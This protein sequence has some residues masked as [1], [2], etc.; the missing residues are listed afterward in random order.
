MTIFDTPAAYL[1]RLITIDVLVTFGVLVVVTLILKNRLAKWLKLS[2]TQGLW[3]G[4]SI[5]GIL[6][7]TIRLWDSNGFDP[8]PWFLHFNMWLS[9]LTPGTNWFLNIAL[10][11][12]SGILLTT[13]GKTGWKSFF[14]L[15]AL[16]C[17]IELFQQYT[18]FGIGDPSDFTAN[19]IGAAIGLLVGKLIHLLLPRQ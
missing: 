3:V 5:C 1:G 6:A 18:K 12:P 15:I 16:S 4:W 11:V 17:S 10:F 8:V 7:F 2:E 9:A 13:F 19:A 14:G